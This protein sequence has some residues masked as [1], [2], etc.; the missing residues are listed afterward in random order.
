MFLL[1]QGPPGRPGVRGQPGGVGEKV[2]VT[3]NKPF[4]ITLNLSASTEVPHSLMKHFALSGN[5]LSPNET[6]QR[7]MKPWARSQRALSSNGTAPH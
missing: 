4:I 1:G 5:L 6:F 2:S 7:I 3:S